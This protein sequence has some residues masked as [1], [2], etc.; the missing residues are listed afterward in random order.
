MLGVRWLTVKEQTEA[1][2]RDARLKCEQDEGECHDSYVRTLQQNKEGSGDT[3]G[4]ARTETQGKETQPHKY[5]VLSE[6]SGSIQW[7]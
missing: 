4:W 3:T 5:F 2:D 1:L 6:S 7:K